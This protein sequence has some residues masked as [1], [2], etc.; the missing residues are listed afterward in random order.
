MWHVLNVCKFS[1][2]FLHRS[3]PH[4]LREE[5]IE[6]SDKNFVVRRQLV[7][8]DSWLKNFTIKISLVDIH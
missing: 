1:Q 2:I 3:I 6:E 7:M 8:L 5:L 4:S